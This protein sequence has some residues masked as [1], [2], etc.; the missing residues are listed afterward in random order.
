MQDLS[1]ITLLKEGDVKITN[2]RAIVGTKSYAIKNIASVRMQVNEP[3]LFL[4]I[5]FMLIAGFCSGL[6]ALANIQDF[7]H[8]LTTFIYLSI[9]TFLLFIFSRKTKYSVRVK[10]SAG[11]LNILQAN[12]RKQAERIVNAM[13]Q[14]L[15]LQE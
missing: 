9:S 12:D 3:K 4:P 2:L 6:L 7:S 11:E 8:L 10:S 14:A 5:F 15:V 1:E 13:N